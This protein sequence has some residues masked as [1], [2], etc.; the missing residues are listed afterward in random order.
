MKA[1]SMPHSSITSL[2]CHLI[3]QVDDDEVEAYLLRVHHHHA[4]PAL[5]RPLARCLRATKCI[6]WT[7]AKVGC[8]S[9]P[10][11]LHMKLE[12]LNQKQPENVGFEKVLKK[13][14]HTQ[15]YVFPRQP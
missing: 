3:D 9:H 11:Y 12:F 5:M 13:G 15:A 7:K 1:F 8:L 14:R 10:R 4:F 2:C 6:I